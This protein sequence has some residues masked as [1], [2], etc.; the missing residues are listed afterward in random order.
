[1]QKWETLKTFHSSGQRDS[2]HAKMENYRE[3]EAQ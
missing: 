1:M 2:K 3:R